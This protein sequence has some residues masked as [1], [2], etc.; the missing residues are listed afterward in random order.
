MRKAISTLP[1]GLV[2]TCA[3]VISASFEPP[4]ET[5]YIKYTPLTTPLTKC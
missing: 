2:S 3:W 1:H 4:P 5:K